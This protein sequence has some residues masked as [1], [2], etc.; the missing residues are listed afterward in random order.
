MERA[1]QPRQCKCGRDENDGIQGQPVQ[2]PGGVG[3]PTETGLPCN[4]LIL[5]LVL[6]L[7]DLPESH[8]ADQDERDAN[9][10]TA[11]VA[12]MGCPLHLDEAKT[13]QEARQ[14]DEHLPCGM[15]GAPE[16]AQP[17]G[18]QSRT[19]L[20][21]D[22][23]RQ[24]CQVVRP[25]ERVETADCEAGDTRYHRRAACQ[26]GCQTVRQVFDVTRHV[27]ERDDSDE[28]NA[29]CESNGLPTNCLL[30]TLDLTIGVGGQVVRDGLLRCR[31]GDGD[32]RRRHRAPAEDSRPSGGRGIRE[33]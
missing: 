22:E 31:Q 9:Q 12:K 30:P 15:S 19:T 26:N 5:V 27:E 23:G 3:R 20:A 8:E 16:G 11:D 28:A 6:P 7:P 17:E 14:A 33:V 10:D 13:H 4:L 29:H 24:A 1:G 32:A 21:D 25:S 18:R 2:N